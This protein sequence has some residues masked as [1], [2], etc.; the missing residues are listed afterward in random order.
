MG[1]SISWLF[2]VFFWLV[3]QPVV[4]QIGPDHHQM[5]QNDLPKCWL[6]KESIRHVAREFIA[7]NPDFQEFILSY[8]KEIDSLSPAEARKRLRTL[9]I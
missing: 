1:A 5:A 2:T 3:A 6:I 7:L 8:C 9:F 4:D